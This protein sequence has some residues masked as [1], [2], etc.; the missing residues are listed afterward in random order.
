MI[1]QR[2]GWDIEVTCA[3]CPRLQERCCGRVRSAAAASASSTDALWTRLRPQDPP[4]SAGEDNLTPS[5]RW[6][7]LDLELSPTLGRGGAVFAVGFG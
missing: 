1:A 2:G 3:F 7:H 4:G 6:D 5:T